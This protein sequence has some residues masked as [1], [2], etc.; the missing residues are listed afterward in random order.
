MT[1]CWRPTPAAPVPN[2]AKSWKVSE[3]GLVYTFSLA[4]GVTCHDNTPLDAND[5][6]YTVDRAF[7][8]ANPSVTQASWGPITG[9]EIVDLLTIRLTL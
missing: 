1:P 5:V 6:E 8:A 9:A 3:D 2:L 7:D 4:E